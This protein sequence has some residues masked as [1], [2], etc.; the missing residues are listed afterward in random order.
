MPYDV[1]EGNDI[2][3]KVNVSGN[4]RPILTGRFVNNDVNITFIKLQPY[5]EETYEYTIKV[6]NVQT[7]SC[8]QT[9]SISM[10]GYQ[11]NLT[12]ERKVTV[13]CKYSALLWIGF[14]K[15]A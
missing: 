7:Y 14:C 3:F 8:G 15:S 12:K 2:E 11:R 9:L 10:L 6:P 4:P 5:L 1:I 13:D